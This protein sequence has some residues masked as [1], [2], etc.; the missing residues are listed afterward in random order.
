MAKG[1]THLWYIAI[2]VISLLSCAILFLGFPYAVI[3][4][5]TG[6]YWDLYHSFHFWSA[7]NNDWAR[8]PV[9]SGII[10]IAFLFPQPALFILW[11]NAVFFALGIT[12]IAWMT[13]ALFHS[14]KAGAFCAIIVLCM[15]I[16]FLHSFTYTLLILTDPLYADLVLIGSMLILGGWLR[17]RTIPL[18]IGF[19]CLGIAALLRPVG[20]CLF[21]VWIGFLIFLWMYERKKRDSFSS[22][23]SFGIA[24]ILLLLPTLLWTTRNGIVY[25]HARV[26][27]FG[28]R[29]LL[30]HVLSL[31][32][33]DDVLFPDAEENRAFIDYLHTFGQTFGTDEDIYRWGGSDNMPNMF[34]RFLPLTPVYAEKKGVIMGM[35]YAQAMFEMDALTTHLAI[36]IIALH[37]I[38]YLQ[39]VAH[40]LF[41]ILKEP[42]Y[43]LADDPHAWY[44]MRMRPPLPQDT[45]QSFYPPDG[46]I[47]A[48]DG[49]RIVSGW[50]THTLQSPF[51]TMLRTGIF[52]ILPFVYDVL[53][54]L[55]L[56]F[57]WYPLRV[58]STSSFAFRPALIVLLC[59][60]F[61][62]LS[63]YL[64]TAMVEGGNERYALPGEIGLH[65]CVLLSIVMVWKWLL[66][67][68]PLR[69]KY[70]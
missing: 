18:W 2:F 34:T 46:A 17:H 27:A 5:D 12:G 69:T 21:P 68:I 35:D 43:T 7:N 23:R 44:L 52:M 31:V 51:I 59:L 56:F 6:S 40:H 25:G 13:T 4:Q 22:G 64:L 20:I 37:P 38:A 39:L 8:T 57:L 58:F 41:L 10:A 62:A 15:E 19:F 24:I 29:N 33:D 14:K 49:N 66:G 9:Y 53:V 30:P 32:Q 60:L 47:D 3:H 45:V 16:F 26:S 63:H 50:M 11:C 48:L 1:I 61:T 55:S 42:I 65:L 67:S 36:R 70:S 28:G 54:L